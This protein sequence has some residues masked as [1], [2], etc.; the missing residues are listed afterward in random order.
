MRK[1]IY[2]WTKFLQT[3]IT[4]TKTQMEIIEVDIEDKKRGVVKLRPRSSRV[5]QLAFNQ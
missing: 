3:T 2:E 5:E 4:E 1:W